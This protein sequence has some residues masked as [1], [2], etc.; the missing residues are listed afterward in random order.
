MPY[1]KKP[2]DNL[3]IIDKEHLFKLWNSWYSFFHWTNI[4]LKRAEILFPSLNKC[5]CIFDAQMQQVG[6]WAS[7][8]KG[9]GGCDSYPVSIWFLVSYVK[10][11]WYVWQTLEFISTPPFYRLSKLGQDDK[12]EGKLSDMYYDASTIVFSKFI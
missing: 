8:W 5:K 11:Q 6:S 3:Y 4:L 12:D 1:Q 9:G 2:C 10:F 7:V